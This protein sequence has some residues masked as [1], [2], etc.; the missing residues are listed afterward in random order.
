MRLATTHSKP[1]CEPTFRE[2]RPTACPENLLSCD[3]FLTNACRSAR[4]RLVPVAA[5]QYSPVAPP[6]ADPHAVASS[7]S[8]RCNTPPSRRVVTRRKEA[9]MPESP[10]RPGVLLE[11]LTWVE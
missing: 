7:P 8:P 2:Y 3:A 9:T 11:D 1:T 5:L 10:T 4:C 6:R